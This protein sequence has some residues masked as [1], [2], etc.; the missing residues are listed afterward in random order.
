[1][2]AAVPSYIPET[3]M[4]GT[5]PGHRF[6][7]YF[8]G[9]TN[10]WKLA[11]HNKTQMLKWVAEGDRSWLQVVD[12]LIQRQHAMAK[13]L[14]N[15]VFV[16]EA[17]AIA[18]FVTGMGYE[19]PLE[20][21]FAFLNPYGVPYLPGS[22]IK[23]VLRKAA[24]ELVLSGE[25]K[26]FDMLDVWR[27]FG[28]D[29]H[30]A[31]LLDQEQIKKAFPHP[32]RLRDWLKQVL[33]DE[34]KREGLDDPQAFLAALPT[35]TG[36]RQSLFNMGA[37]AFWDAFPKGAL[38]VDI[39][40]PHHSGYLQAKEKDRDFAK[41][42]PHDSEKP[43]PIP[44]L[45]IAPGARFVFFVQR[46]GD[47]GNRNWQG[48][49]EQCF[50]HAFDWLG[51]GAKTSVGYGALVR[52]KGSLDQEDAPEAL[53]D[54][55]EMP[56]LPSPADEWLTKTMQELTAQP[57]VTEEQAWR[58]KMLAQRWQA[59]EDAELK[60]QVLERIRAYWVKRGWWENPPGKSA[61][62]AKAMYEGQS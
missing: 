43:N 26:E 10:A 62:R 15:A 28:F 54:P 59:I 55:A 5:P 41:K 1:M 20:N 38:R 25:A 46:L 29:G 53:D 48:I 45:T 44:F 4:N 39:M 3:E 9:W 22:S 30:A 51:F 33:P 18:P 24:E 16:V 61:R 57:N 17:K 12:A 35:H 52:A 31:F 47:T 8:R 27:L 58:G 19:H 37:L 23:G 7:L 14:S 11:E 32:S 49:V 6:G 50:A 42:T 40:T 13:Q 2:R 60:Q 21:G 56:S 36:L 34:F